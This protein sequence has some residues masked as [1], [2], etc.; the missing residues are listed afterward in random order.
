[1]GTLYCKVDLI[2]GGFILLVWRGE[3]WL[4]L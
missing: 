1:M 4:E 3:F 2:V